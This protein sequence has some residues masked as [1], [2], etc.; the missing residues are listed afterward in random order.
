MPGGPWSG[1]AHTCA[2]MR[3]N[4]I[5]RADHQD[6]GEHHH[7]GHSPLEAYG[8]EHIAPIRIGRP[9]VDSSREERPRRRRR[10]QIVTSFLGETTGRAIGRAD[11]GSPGRGGSGPGIRTGSDGAAG[12][13]PFYRERGP[14]SG[15]P[16]A[17]VACE[18]T[19]SRPHRCALLLHKYEDSGSRLPVGVLGA[20]GYAGR[21]LC[22]LIE[23]HPR[24]GLVW[25]TAHEQQAHQSPDGTTRC[26]SSGPRKLRWATRPWFSVPC[27]M[28][29]RRDG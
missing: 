1:S 17:S 6:N 7:R 13:A 24:L 9:T 14:G 4:D 20:S 16:V 22:A 18:D 10:I 15:R 29:H 26:G 28:G 3:V 2:A 19:T 5:E 23:R 21:E 11:R 12:A 25:A 8:S 27:R